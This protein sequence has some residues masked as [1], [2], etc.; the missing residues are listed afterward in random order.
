MNTKEEI[1]KQYWGYDTFRDSQEAIIDSVLSKKN[2]LALLPTGGGK[3]ICYQVPGMVNEG[4]CIVVS[5]LIALMKDQVQNLKKRGIKAIAI[6]SGMNK[7]EIDIA[8]DNCVYG[9]IKFLYVSPERMLTDIFRARVQKMKVN[10]IAVDEA[11]CISQWGHDFRPAFKQINEIMEILPKETPLLAVTATANNRVIKDICETVTIADANVFKKSFERDNLGYLVLHE[12]NKEERLLKILRKANSC[13]IVYVNTRRRTKQVADFLNNKGIKADFYHGGLPQ[14]IRD[15]KQKD[16]IEDKT[17][18]IVSTNA[19]GMGIDKPNVRVVVHFELPASPEAY[20]QEAGRAGRDGKK[21]FA[22]LLYKPSDKLTLEK[23]HELE[24]PEKSE[25]KK[26]YNCLGNFYQLAIG[27]GEFNTYEFDLADFCNRFNLQPIVAHHCI[28]LLSLAGYL[29]VSEAIYR[30]PRVKVRMTN[31]NLYG[32]QIANKR[33]EPLIQLL[34]RNN[35]GIFDSYVKISPYTISNKLKINEQEVIKDLNYLTKIEVLTFKPASD[36][37]VLSYSVDRM[38]EDRL[39]FPKEIYLDRKKVKKQQL[40]FM[41][42]LC[43]SEHICR[44]KLLLS[45]FDETEFNNCGICDVCIQTAKKQLQAT[46]FQ[47]IETELLSVLAEKEVSL[48]ELVE[49]IS[50]FDE[51]EILEVIQWKLDNNEFFY[52]DSH[53]IIS[54]KK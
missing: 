32:F 37:P 40:D 18:V 34:L 21:S 5:P 36:V 50:G 25:I 49:G 35:E 45:Y 11:H 19:F 3:S 10:L 6:F 2:S 39:V 30:P 7:R 4:I 23:F 29:T 20:F 53:K 12:E 26:V 8:L 46:G 47:K 43:E 51:K 44:S 54:K 41:I 15:E 31:Q 1:L 9:D 17:Q 48:K 22:V 24:F 16:W 52:N 38:H 42:K 28:S 14:Q 27:G 33:Y 13:G